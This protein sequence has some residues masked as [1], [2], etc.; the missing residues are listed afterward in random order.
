MDMGLSLESI[1]SSVKFEG[2]AEYRYVRS[3]ETYQVVVSD[4]H[5]FPMHV[6][7][8]GLYFVGEVARIAVS[9][10]D[11]CLALYGGDD[12]YGIVCRPHIRDVTQKEDAFR[13]LFLDDAV[14]PFDVG[15]L[16]MEVGD[17]QEFH[18]TRYGLYHT[19]PLSVRVFVRGLITSVQMPL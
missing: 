1:S 19:Y 11:V 12:L 14:Y 10:K 4:L 6:R 9:G 5:S 15:G 18:T 17:D 3:S 8:Y 13:V 7:G 16:L 2:C